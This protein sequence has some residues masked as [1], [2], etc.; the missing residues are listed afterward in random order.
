MRIRHTLAAGAALAVSTVGL[1][2]VGT[3][4]MSAARLTVCTSDKSYSQ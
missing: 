4:S 2:A 3:T 1:V